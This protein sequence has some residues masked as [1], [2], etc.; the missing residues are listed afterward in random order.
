M[1]SFAQFVIKQ[2]PWFFQGL[3]LL[4]I[5][6]PFVI[7]GAL[8]GLVLLGLAVGQWSFLGWIAFLPLIYL[9]WLLIL[10]GIFILLSGMARAFYRKPRREEFAYSAMPISMILCVYHYRICATL[11]AMP[12]VSWLLSDSSFFRWLFFRSYSTHCRIP[13][14]GNSVNGAIQDPDITTIGPNVMIGGAS[15]LIAHSF[16]ASSHGRVIYQSAPITIARGVTVAG[17]TLIELG[18]TIEADALVEPFSRVAAFTRIPAGEVWGGVPAVFLRRRDGL[19]RLDEVAAPPAL[20][21]PELLDLVATALGLPRQ[22]ITAASGSHNCDDWDSLGRMAIA[23]A[24]EARH[25]IRLNSNQIFSLDSVAALAR[26]VDAAAEGSPASPKTAPLPRDPELLP[27]LDGL[28]VSRQLLDRAAGLEPPPGPGLRVVVAASFVAEPL[29]Q[30][31]RLWSQAFGLAIESE[32]AGFNQIVATLLDPHGL[33]HRNRAG[34]N[35]VLCRPEDLCTSRDA[36]GRIAADLI[37]DAAASF[38]SSGGSLLIADLPPVVSPYFQGDRSAVPALQAHWL[39]RLQAIPG[40]RGF[41]FSGL[42]G[43]FGSDQAGDAEMEQVASTPYCNAIYGLLG[44]DLAREVRR[45]R[46]P[47]KKVIA[48][49]ADGTLWGGVLGEDGP[50]GVQ[51]GGVFALFQKRLR[52][53]REQGILLTL[54]SKNE[55][56]DVWNLLRHHPDCELRPDDFVSSRIG[57]GDKSESLRQL[58]TELNLGLDSFVF[59]DDN[60]VER[61][62]VEARCPQVTV[63]PLSL[64]PADYLPQL[65]RLWCFDGAGS[66]NED[67]KRTSMLEYE[68]VRRAGLEQ[69]DDLASYLQ[70]LELEVTFRPAEADDLPRLAQ[71]TQKTNQFN[72]SLQRRS[73]EEIRQLAATQASLWVASVEDRFG[74]YGLVGAVILCPFSVHGSA[75]ARLDTFLLSCRALGRGVEEAIVH[76][77]AAAAQDQGLKY[78]CAPYVE[79]PRNRPA[80]DFFRHQGWSDQNGEFHLALT[81]LPLLP[82]HVSLRLGAIHRPLFRQG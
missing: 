5:F 66:S 47:A 40:I 16:T 32:F 25:G 12:M 44:R 74:S 55:P 51:P 45:R 72:L 14:T 54:V 13:L 38:A 71:L 26:H 27:L 34:L 52:Q 28:Q 30:S 29:A 11:N 69:S 78:L 56:E 76:G 70:S 15:R 23:A 35:L 9:L 64:N 36:D 73:E 58:A 1:T 53:L 24:L 65:N 2:S 61:A 67:L 60:P 63:L 10:M 68:R 19:Q 46:L 77:I 8:T 50:E 62:A 18:V 80:L 6:L 39:Q 57:W 20:D 3:L 21:R 48:L 7:A 37:L 17:N 42:I 75:A 31:L 22:R 59:V 43:R 33:F 81:T 82:S 79:A 41:D 4:G 49:D